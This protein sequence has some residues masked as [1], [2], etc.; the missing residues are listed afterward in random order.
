M[1]I[2]IKEFFYGG[3]LFSL[4]KYTADHVD[5]IFITSMIATVPTGLLASN[6]ISDKKINHYSLSYL[7][8]ITTLFLTSINFYFLHKYTKLHRHSILILSILF[9]II[10]NLSLFVF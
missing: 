10:I 1:E 2:P 7:Q 6:L 3:I 9:W 5:N 4:I 8:S